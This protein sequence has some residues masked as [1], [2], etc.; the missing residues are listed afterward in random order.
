M[1]ATL[2][3]FNL[4]LTLG[5]AAPAAGA[6]A[7]PAA[8]AVDYGYVSSGLPDHVAQAVLRGLQRGRAAFLELDAAACRETTEIACGQE[9]ARNRGLSR[10]VLSTLH[11][12]EPDSE[13]VL[14]L[15]EAESGRVVLRSNMVCEICGEA[16]LETMAEALAGDFTR[17]LA[18][19]EERKSVV[20]LDGTPAGAVV[21]LDGR[22]VGKLPWS[23]VVEPGTHELRV[24]HPDHEAMTRQLVL[25]AEVE[26]AIDVLL[27]PRRAAE[28]GAAGS[29]RPMPLSRTGWRAAV[30]LIGGGSA[31]LA[32]GI[33]LLGV[34]GL[35]VCRGRPRD[36]DGDCPFELTTVPLGAV[37]TGVGAASVGAG[38]ALLVLHD[39]RKRSIRATVGARGVGIAGRF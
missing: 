28:A 29:G 26:E 3:L 39:V 24:S 7:E 14:A 34:A 15:V 30:G 25:S 6:D 2:Q 20:R 10:F 9:L 17:K 19:Q 36:A 4:L 5:S 32:G 31:A 33:V 13:I 11:E 37:L 23:G 18:P 21:E 38:A 8:G 1:H 27:A 16:E 12:N 35:P 22:V